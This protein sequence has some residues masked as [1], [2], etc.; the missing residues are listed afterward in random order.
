M[1][2]NLFK[3]IINELYDRELKM[4]AYNSIWEIPVEVKK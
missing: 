4:Y 2:R 1:L 3:I